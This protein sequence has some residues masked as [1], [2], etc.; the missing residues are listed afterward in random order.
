M[1]QLAA[2]L[3]LGRR[4]VSADKIPATG[5]KG[6]CVQVSKPTTPLCSTIQQAERIGFPPQG[7]PVDLE[8]TRDLIDAETVGPIS[9]TITYIMLSNGQVSFNL[10]SY[11]VLISALL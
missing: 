2:V 6:A 7:V 10:D 3:Q 4:T 9:W 5:G 1:W 11:Y 8:D